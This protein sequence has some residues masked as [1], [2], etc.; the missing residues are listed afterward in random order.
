MCDMIQA[1]AASKAIATVPLAPKQLCEDPNIY[2][3]ETQADLYHDCKPS[4]DVCCSKHA[5]H[6][7]VHIHSCMGHTFILHACYESL[8]SMEQ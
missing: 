4:V 3:V 8:M 5:Q 7:L 6:A 1:I 2:L